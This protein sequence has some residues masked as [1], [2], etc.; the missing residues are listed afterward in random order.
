MGGAFVAV[1]D[2]ASA[3][4][5]NPAGLALGGSYFSLV[6]DGSL[7]EAEAED[8]GTGGRPFAGP[9]RPVNAPA[10]A[11]VLPAQ[12]R[13]RRQPTATSATRPA[14]AAD[15]ASCRRDVG[16]VVSVST[17]PSASTLK[18]VH[19]FAAS[20]VVPAGDR[21]DLLDGAGDLPE[22]STN[23]F[24][25]DVGVMALAWAVRAGRD[26]AQSRRAGFRRPPTAAC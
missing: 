10:R 14:R 24:D 26:A 7:G 6:L 4:Y 8:A 13:P 18:R 15:D 20:G 1:A 17:S 25:V 22:Q 5:W 12:L 23:K 2:D 19:G 11:F 21:D 9:D 3:V 16:A